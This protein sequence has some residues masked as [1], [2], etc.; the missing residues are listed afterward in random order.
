MAVV[1]DLRAEDGEQLVL[2]VLFPE[3][4]LFLIHR[5][6]VYLF[7]AAGIQIFQRLLVVFIAV[8]LQMGN[9]GHDGVQL[10]LGRHVGLVLTLVFVLLTAC[11]VGALLQRAHTHHEKFIQIGA[12]NGKEFH[13]LCQRDILVLAQH[14]HTAVKVQPA[15]FTV[16][17]DRILFHS[18]LLPFS[19]TCGFRRSASAHVSKPI[20]LSHHRFCQAGHGGGLFHRSKAPVL[21]P[22]FDDGP[23]ALL[24]HPR[25]GAESVLPG[26]VQIDPRQLDERCFTSGCTARPCLPRNGKPKRQ[27]DAHRADK[28]RCPQKSLFCFCETGFLHPIVPDFL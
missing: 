8:L 6:E 3:A 22:V 28:G 16:D 1:H 4:L 24:P 20:P 17:E 25:Q 12:I 19:L 5:I 7:I 11:K 27:R 14:Q 9:L 13:L 21:L 10:F 2:E 15:E 26:G 18:S 23:G